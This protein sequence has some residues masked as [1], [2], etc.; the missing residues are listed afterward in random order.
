ASVLAQKEIAT[1]LVLRDDRVW[2]KFF[3][4]AMSRFF[5]GYFTERGVEI[6]REAQVTQANG[7]AALTSV[8]V[9]SHGTRQCDLMVVGVGVRP[10]TDVLMDSGIELGDGVVVN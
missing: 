1:S 5:E 7:Q 10:A 6:I 4:P 2:K 9:G 3:T 8:A